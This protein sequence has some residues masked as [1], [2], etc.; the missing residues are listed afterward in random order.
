MEIRD[1][2]IGDY[3]AFLKL[4]NETF[5]ENE[6]RIY[7][8]AGHVVNFVKEKGGKFRGFCVDDGGDVFIGFLTYWV[9]R[10]FIYIEHFAVAPA[11][12]SKNVGRKMLS[13]LF[14]TVGENVL[15][16][17]ERPICE[18]GRRRISF[19][20]KIGFRLRKDINYVQPPY[21]TAQSGVE[22][23]L[24]T[25]GDVKLR[26]KSDLREMLAEVYNVNTDI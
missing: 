24:M 8:S 7:K 2:N 13:H 6:R 21:S 17:V 1:L 14:E 25:H 16:E 22:M 12:R 11:H 15:L 18:D 4:Y 20:E 19:Y 3:P 5:P 9:F 23:M 26:D 10:N